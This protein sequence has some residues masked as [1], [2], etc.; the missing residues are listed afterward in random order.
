MGATWDGYGV[1]FALFSENAEAVDLCLFDTDYGAPEVARIR[2]REHTDNVWH[3]R[4]PEARPGLRYGYRV[5]GPWNPAAGER[6]NPH[7]LL[8]DP[9]AKAITGSVE[10]SDAM[11]AYPPGPNPD[12]DLEFSNSDSAPGMPKAVVIEN[13][14]TWGVDRL[15]RR[16]WN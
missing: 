8:I 14:L 10:W 2:L 4:L 13:S 11:F 12:A 15:L 6:F 3:A 5:Y 1:N 9:Y 7:Q 16:R